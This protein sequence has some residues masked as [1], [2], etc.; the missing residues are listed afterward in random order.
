MLRPTTPIGSEIVLDQERDLARLG[1]GVADELDGVVLRIGMRQTAGILGDAAIV[2]ET[3]NRFYVR[4]RRPAQAQ[5]FGLE[6]ARTGLAQGRGRKFLQHRPAPVMQ[7]KK[8]K[9]RNKKGRPVSRLP[10]GAFY[11]LR[12]FIRT[13]RTQFDPPSIRPPRS[14][15]VPTRRCGRWLWRGTRRGLRPWRREYGRCPCR[16]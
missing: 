7:L 4:E 3:R 5:P 15:E 16:H 8:R 2:G 13:R 1:C 9:R 12:R 6:D 14:S 11:G 10:F